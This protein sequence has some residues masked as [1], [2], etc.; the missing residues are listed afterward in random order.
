MTR[1]EQLKL[2]TAAKEG[3]V[4]QAVLQS[5]LKRF[6]A[7]ETKEILEGLKYDSLNGNFYFERW[8]MYVGV[9]FDGYIHT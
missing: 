6:P 7:E 5:I 4:P 9:E 1:D 8:G 2:E 3:F